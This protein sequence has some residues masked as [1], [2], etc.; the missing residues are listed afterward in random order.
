MHQ[1]RV[2]T[3]VVLLIVVVV[4][5]RL[6]GDNSS[7]PRKISLK[8][9]EDMRGLDA[10]LFQ[11]AESE[12]KRREARAAARVTASNQGNHRGYNSRSLSQKNLK[13]FFPIKIRLKPLFY[14]FQTAFDSKAL[15]MHNRRKSI[16]RRLGAN[17]LF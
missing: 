8:L 15:F 7:G 2:W 1:M 12:L 17:T 11:P 6:I 3:G 10:C 5:F 14:L 9:L 13:I 4:G 16:S